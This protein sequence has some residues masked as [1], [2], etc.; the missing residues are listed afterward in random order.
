MDHFKKQLCL[1]GFFFSDMVVSLDFYFYLSFVLP[2]EIHSMSL[3][4][5]LTL[6]SSNVQSAEPMEIDNF[7]GDLYFCPECKSVILNE[8]TELRDRSIC[9]DFCKLCWFYKQ[10]CKVFN[11]GIVKHD[12]S[13]I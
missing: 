1:T 13:L 6:V 5:L 8:V 12:L 7:K 10:T 3:Q 4:T 2:V 9:C 11:N